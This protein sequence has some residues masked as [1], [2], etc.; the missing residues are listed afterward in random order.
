MAD[1]EIDICLSQPLIC[2]YSESGDASDSSFKNS[3]AS[4]SEIIEEIQS[5]GTN[6]MIFSILADTDNH[7]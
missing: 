5:Q 4:E 6:D 7:Q 2:D 1:S 3:A